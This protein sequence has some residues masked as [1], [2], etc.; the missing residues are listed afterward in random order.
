MSYAH[1]LNTFFIACDTH[2]HAFTQHTKSQTHT[3]KLKA[4]LLAALL[5]LRV[6][7]KIDILKIIYF[8]K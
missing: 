2:T 4:M 5:W 8:E 3:H 1:N 6:A 7:N